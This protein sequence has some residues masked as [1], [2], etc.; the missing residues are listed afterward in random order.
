MALKFVCSY[1]ILPDRRGSG[2]WSVSF[3]PFHL[4]AAGLPDS[5]HLCTI[6]VG[7]I[8][9]EPRNIGWLTFQFR[10]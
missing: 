2:A 4:Q 1:G 10:C 5:R 6:E 3:P 7:F 8:V 9:H